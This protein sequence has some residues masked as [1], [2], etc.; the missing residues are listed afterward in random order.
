MAAALRWHHS[1]AVRSFAI[2]FVATHVPLLALIALAVLQPGWLSPLGVLAAALGSTLVASV[3]VVSVLWRLFHP[4]RAAADGLHD[5]MTRGQPLRLQ[6]GVQDEVGRL[7]KVLVLALAHL[8]RSR[9]PLLVAGALSLERT[10]VPPAGAACAQQMVALLEVNQWQ[11]LEEHG[12]L[13]RLQEVQSAMNR[14]LAA[15][16][17]R[18][19]IMLPWGRGRFLLVL[20]P[21]GASGRLEA[22]CAGFRVSSSPELYSCS[23]A[24]EPHNR[25]PGAWLGILQRLE[26]QLFALSLQREGRA[27]PAGPAASRRRS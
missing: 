10:A 1:I 27:V 5:F 18:G 25:H 12:Q 22:L 17:L 4:L 13:E 21:G 20:H 26:G 15:A 23:G 6:A 3:L 9:T 2:A 19:E 8:D 16:L 7:V 11:A 14:T 24:L